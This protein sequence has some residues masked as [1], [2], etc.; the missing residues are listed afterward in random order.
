[1][2]EST[3]PACPSSLWPPQPHPPPPQLFC[4]PGCQ[5]GLP[6]HSSEDW[7]PEEEVGRARQGVPG[8]EA[9]PS[10]GIQDMKTNPAFHI[11]IALGPCFPH[12]PFCSAVNTL[13][14]P[15]AHSWR[16]LPASLSASAIPRG[17]GCGHSEPPLWGA[18]RPVPLPP[19]SSGQ[20]FPSQVHLGWTLGRSGSGHRP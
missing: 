10:Q 16:L 4:R 18:L 2:P 11:F 13:A 5:F 14:L 1:L 19:P 17:R 7:L 9:S 12:W 3:W 8:P 6:G 20:E 15:P